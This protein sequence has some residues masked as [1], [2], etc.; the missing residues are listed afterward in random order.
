MREQEEE[1]GPNRSVGKRHSFRTP[2]IVLCDLVFNFGAT[3]KNGEI[4][5]KYSDYQRQG[6]CQ[7]NKIHE[8]SVDE[9]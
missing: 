1:V 2:P 7:I 6:W 4:Y 5:L 8:T 3:G 9:S